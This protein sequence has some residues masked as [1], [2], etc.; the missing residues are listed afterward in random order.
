MVGAVFDRVEEDFLA[1][2]RPVLPVREHK[3]DGAAKP[4]RVKARQVIG[5]PRIVRSQALCKNLEIGHDLRMGC[6]MW[7]YL[8]QQAGFEQLLDGNIWLSC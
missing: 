5:G 4:H 8:A 7:R 6:G 2:H 3:A 1:R